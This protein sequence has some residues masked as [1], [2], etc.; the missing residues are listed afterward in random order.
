MAPPRRL[1]ENTMK[2]SELLRQAKMSGDE[3]MKLFREIERICHDRDLEIVKG[4][5]PKHATGTPSLA[6]STK[7]SPGSSEGKKLL[8]LGLEFEKRENAYI[9]FTRS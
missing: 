9:W 7:T 1:K 6:V 2:V 5:T 4:F 8:D 3:R